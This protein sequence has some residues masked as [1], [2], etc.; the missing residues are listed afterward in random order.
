M[1]YYH[2]ALIDLSTNHSWRTIQRR[3]ISLTEL[4]WV[5]VLFGLL[6]VSGIT[7]SAFMFRQMHAIAQRQSEECR[8]SEQRLTTLI[9]GFE[10]RLTAQLQAVGARVDASEGR[11]TAQLQ[12][13][14]ARVDAS[15]GRLTAQLQGVGARVDASEGRLTAQIQGAEDRQDD[16]GPAPDGP[17]AN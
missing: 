4:Q 14:G 10:Q 17:C 5:L 8:A 11:L 2:R 12:G 1:S 9:E 7:V 13:V 16:R 3:E 6:L 15:E